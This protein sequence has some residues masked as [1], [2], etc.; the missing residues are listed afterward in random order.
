MSCSSFHLVFFMAFFLPRV[1]T[2]ILTRAV[3]FSPRDLI[4]NTVA[5][6]CPP[7]NRPVAYPRLQETHVRKII[8]AIPGRRQK[9]KKHST[10]PA[11][12]EEADEG[13]RDV[14]GDA[15]DP[16]DDPAGLAALLEPLQAALQ[17]AL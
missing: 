11:G 13:R 10:V 6:D 3:L 16:N 14:V 17:D 12:G 7:N 4:L 1:L 9:K 2:V 8:V 15:A 5:N